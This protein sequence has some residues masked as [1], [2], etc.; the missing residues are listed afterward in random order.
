MCA[1][2]IKSAL[3]RVVT[4]GT[5]TYSE[6]CGSHGDTCTRS[7]TSTVTVTSPAF[8]GTR[9]AKYAA[10]CLCRDILCFTLATTKIGISFHLLR[11]LRLLL[12]S[13]HM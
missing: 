3:T 2:G 6:N 12:A 4:V 10:L 13:V 11:L 1:A 9:K 7:Y 8:S 5:D